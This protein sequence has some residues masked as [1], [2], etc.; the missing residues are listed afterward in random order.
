MA[1]LRARA[2]MAKKNSDRRGSCTHTH[3]TPSLTRGSLATF[4]IT[5]PAAVVTMDEG[6]RDGG[7]DGGR[8]EEV[9]VLDQVPLRGRDGRRRRRVHAQHFVEAT[10]FF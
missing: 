8:D 2:H 6:G 1:F 5:I 9:G 4:P 7:T 10:D 3:Y